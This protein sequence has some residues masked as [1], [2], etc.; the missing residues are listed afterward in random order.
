MALPREHFIQ[1]MLGD[2]R[3]EVRDK[4]GVAGWRRRLVAHLL[5][6]HRVVSRYGADGR[7]G[8]VLTECQVSLSGRVG[9]E[10]WSHCVAAKRV[11]VECCCSTWCYAVQKTH[12]VK[13]GRI[14]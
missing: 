5:R 9:H 13:N 7:A 14:N 12:Q 8:A 1:L 6:M 4:Q 2:T 10:L 3:A 11:N